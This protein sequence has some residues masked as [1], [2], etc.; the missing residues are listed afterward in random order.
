MG[1]PAFWNG[2]KIYTRRFFGKSVVTND[3]KV[4]MEDANGKNLDKFFDQW[5]YLKN[6]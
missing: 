6:S 2:L 5:V 1:E 3:F 4:A